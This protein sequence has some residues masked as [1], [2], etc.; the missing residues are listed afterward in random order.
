MDQYSRV[1]ALLTGMVFLM[2]VSACSASRNKY[3]VQSPISNPKEN[4]E[5]INVPPSSMV[6]DAI[7][8]EGT[9]IS[10]LGSHNGWHQYG[11]RVARTLRYGS[12][13]ASIEPASK[14]EIVLNTSKKLSNRIGENI[15]VNVTTPRQ[16]D[17][18]KLMVFKTS[19]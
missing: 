14:E 7:R 17:G 12:T 19:E 15:E 13:F 8:L 1:H 5:V 11:F 3:A 4:P 16:R 2:V 9:L 6:K 10:N 18:G